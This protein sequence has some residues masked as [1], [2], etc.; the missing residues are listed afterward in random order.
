MYVYIY[1]CIYMCVCIYI[2]M[3]YAYMLPSLGPEDFSIKPIFG[4]FKQSWGSS[5]TVPGRNLYRGY[6]QCFAVLVSVGVKPLVGMIDSHRT[7]LLWQRVQ[8]FSV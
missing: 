4:G 7:S 6:L 1:I 8:V 2:Y 5:K 3:I